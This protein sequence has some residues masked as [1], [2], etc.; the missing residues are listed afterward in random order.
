MWA[1]LHNRGDALL[2]ACNRFTFNFA[3]THP[4]LVMLRPANRA[5]Q[6]LRRAGCGGC[7]RH[8]RRRRGR[9]APRLPPP[10][11]ATRM[12]REAWEAGGRKAGL[13]RQTGRWQAGR[14]RAGRRERRRTGRRW[15]GRRRGMRRE[16]AGRE[17]WEAAGLEA[18]RP[19]AG[20][21]ACRHRDCHCPQEGESRLARAWSKCQTKPWEA[22]QLGRG[23]P[24]GVGGTVTSLRP[25]FLKSVRVWCVRGGT[26]PCASP[27]AAL[28]STEEG[29]DNGP[30]SGRT[31]FRRTDSYGPG[32]VT[33]IIP[34]YVIR[35]L[36][37]I[38]DEPSSVIRNI[39]GH[40]RMS[41]S[42]D[43]SVE[44]GGGKRGTALRAGAV[45]T[46]REGTVAARRAA[47]EGVGRGE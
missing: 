20:R 31:L 37:R 32:S 13:R 2:A 12:S 33:R 19:Q 22:A 6:P 43:L 14:R 11:P 29:P 38:T 9:P 45:A 5:G 15:A 17:A 34:V 40:P 36:V 3:H 4:P 24:L 39:I 21:E 35:I 28:W 26:I 41:S 7:S 1:D 23:R 27:A 47:H 25:A 8:T 18:R 46:P 44:R 10:S 42:R 16:V 30:Y